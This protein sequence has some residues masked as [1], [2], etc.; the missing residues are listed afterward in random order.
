MKYLFVAFGGFILV[1]AGLLVVTLL[2]RFGVPTKAAIGL[3]LGVLLIT[4]FMWILDYL[5]GKT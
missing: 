1:F 3:V 5:A 4:F 2:E